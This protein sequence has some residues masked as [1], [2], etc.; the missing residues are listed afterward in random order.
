MYGKHVAMYICIYVLW[1]MN[2][3]LK[4]SIFKVS[5]IKFHDIALFI[6]DSQDIDIKSDVVA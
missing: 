3:Y 4:Q 1:L 5:T 2:V 6:Q